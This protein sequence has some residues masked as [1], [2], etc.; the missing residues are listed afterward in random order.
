MKFLA[1]QTPFSLRSGG[2]AKTWLIMKMSAFLMLAFCL[3]VS[4]AGYSQKLTI[5]EKNAPPEK[6]FAEISR[7]TGYTFVY[8]ESLLQ[9]AKNISISTRNASLE[10]VLHECFKGQPITYSIINKLIILKEKEGETSKEEIFF[11]PPAPPLSGRVTD[12]NGQPLQGATVQ[13]KGTSTSTASDVNGNFTIQVPETGGVLLISFVGFETV[14][15][16][17]SG[18]ETVNV[19]LKR[20]IFETEEVVVI[21]YGTVRKRDVTGSISQ[22]KSEEINA[23]PSA[24]VLMSL[25]GRAPGIHIRQGSGAPGSGITVR[26]RGGNSI[27]GGNEPLY[28]IDGFPINGNPTHLNNMDIESVEILK[29]ATATAIYGSRGANG[30]VII[31]TK[32]GR[33]GRTV[34]DVETSYSSQRLVKKL[35]LMNAKEYAMFYN[36]QR[37]NDNLSQYFTQA[38]IDGF[39]EGFDWQDLVFQ[40]APMSSTAV[41]VN[42]GT[43]NTQ[44]SLSGSMFSQ[45]G[46]I[47]GSDYNRYSLVSSLNHK[48]S[49]KF[50]VNVTSTLSRLITARRDNGGGNRGN[51]MIAAAVS[52]PPTLTPYNEDGSYRVLS[53]AYPFIATDIRN[54]LNFIN[55]QS[56]Q[57]RVNVALI[58]AAV[59]YNITPDLVLKIA[60]GIENRD[61][62]TD[63]Y[64]TT[65]FFNSLGS[66]SVFAGQFTSLLNEN[67]LTYKKTV[68]EKHRINALV[69]FTY[70]D[71]LNTSLS[72]GGTGFLSDI[73][74]TYDL[75]AAATAAVPG[76]NYI[77]SVLLSYLGRVNYNFDEKYLAT[78]SLRRDGSSRYSEGNKWGYFPSAAFAW[79]VSN[80]DFLS[81]N[82]TISDLKLRTSWGLTGSQAIDPYRTLNQLSAGRTVFNNSLANTFAPGTVY[83]GDLKWETTEQIDIGVD[84]GVL[85]NRLTLTADYYIKNTRDLLSRVIL[86][87][88]MGYSSTTQNV[89]RI[90]NKGVELGLDADVIEGAFSWNVNTNIAFNRNKVVELNNGEDLLRDNISMVVINDVTSILREGQ[91]VGRFWGYREEGYDNKGDIIFSDLNHDGAITSD[92]KTYIGDPNPDFIYGLNSTMR[93]KT[94]ELNVFFQGMKGND[95]F[96]A[97]AISNT[98]DYG[99]GLNMTK[100]VFN[101]RWTPT[102]TD[103]KYPRISNKTP[104]RV[105]DR[106][107]E[108][109]S[110]LRMKNIM[111]SYNLP[112]E[113]MSIGWARSLQLYVSGQNLITFTNYSWWDPET[114]FRIDH[115]SYPGSKSVTFGIRAGL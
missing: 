25:S 69:G 11:S 67:T 3:N 43:E 9:K 83:P 73:F 8:T 22:V 113:S 114:N 29:D 30:V 12:E 111:L 74:E 84:L 55:E 63:V 21:G 27:L 70:Q 115:H 17:V 89:G 32:K 1:C 101:N 44:F 42:G 53:T 49:N 38:Q 75:G 10:Q 31:T 16:A 79:R 82:R 36:E 41:N 7:Q 54:P 13:L 26:I 60:G 51:S 108:D 52:A 90:Q 107:I 81:D 77:K 80:E 24:N 68:N 105:S 39:G 92:D 33:A 59:N 19:S 104:I 86:P 45:E 88:S 64:T 95:I 71:F 14:E 109:G 40:T 94:W 46:I 72:G 28:V 65:N 66:A 34:V 5:S 110:Y 35:D 48:I 99:F 76:S 97:S 61:E 56:S 15:R 47:K 4:A 18:I 58:N 50:S 6:V 85:R 103:A 87:S 37:A 2:V 102:N 98:L 23:Y 112:L 96:N 106:M 93:F 57:I 91:P 62:R 20:Q 78:I 100:D